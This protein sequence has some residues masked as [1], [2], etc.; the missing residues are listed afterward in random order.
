MS[1]RIMETDTVLGNWFLKKKN[2]CLILNLFSD[3][4]LTYANEQ[5][6]K[7]TTLPTKENK[8]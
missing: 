2:N 3:A 1:L 4:T 6:K 8:R 5:Q 7:Q